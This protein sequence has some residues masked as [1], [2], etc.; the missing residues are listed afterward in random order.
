MILMQYVNIYLSSAPEPGSDQVINIRG[1]SIY[2]F[3][4]VS[5]PIIAQM[6][7]VYY[8]IHKITPLCFIVEC[9]RWYRAREHSPQKF[10]QLRYIQCIEIL[11]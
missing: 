3:Y 5:L 4:E 7:Y 6:W 10:D 9:I 1:D 2:D 8:V 11:F